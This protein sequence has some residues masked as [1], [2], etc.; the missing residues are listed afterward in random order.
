M[1]TKIFHLFLMFITLSFGSRI[2]WA[3]NTRTIYTQVV[4]GLPNLQFQNGSGTITLPTYSGQVCTL[5][6]TETFSSKT[7]AQD[8]LPDTDASRNFGSASKRWSNVYSSGIGMFNLM[9]LTENATPASVPSAGTVLVYPKTDGFLYTWDGTT[10]RPASSGA[11]AGSITN[12]MLATMAANTIKGNNTG[13]SAS[14]SDL[15]ASQVLTMLGT[16]PVTSGGTGQTSIPAARNAL[17]PAQTGLAGDFLETDGTNVH[18][19]RVNS[20]GGGGSLQWIEDANSPTPLLENHIRVYAFQAGVSQTIYATIKVPS[21]FSTGNPIK[22]RTFIYTPDSSGTALIQSTAT[23]I[24]T[25]FD[26]M[27]STANQYVSTNTA[28]TLSAG[29][30]NIPQILLLDLTSSSGQINSITV[31]PGDIIQVS[32]YRGSDTATSDIKVPVYG[33][34]VTFQ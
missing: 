11:A 32:L 7:F 8:V 30:V 28:T 16:I 17:L 34:E 22:L 21:T 12:S 24:R 27:S 6:G 9:Q 5:A 20:G 14:P 29:T 31:N 15:T 4:S 25:N 3:G 10:E 33:A 19:L 26:T 1:K 18:W 23:L 13:S 2:C